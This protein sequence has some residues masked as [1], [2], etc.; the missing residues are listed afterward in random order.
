MALKTD[1]DDQILSAVN[2]KVEEWK[3]CAVL[4][5]CP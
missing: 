1:N 5:S 2:S 3:V 4:F